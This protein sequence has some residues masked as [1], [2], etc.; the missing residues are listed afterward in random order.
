[1]LKDHL[2]LE[3]KKD[4]VYYIFVYL[5][6]QQSDL[7]PLKIKLEILFH[8]NRCVTWHCIVTCI[9]TCIPS[10]EGF[11]PTVTKL[12]SGQGNP[13]AATA[14]D[15]AEESNPYMSPFQKMTCIIFIIQSIHTSSFIKKF[16]IFFKKRQDQDIENIDI[17]ELGC[18]V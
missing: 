17:L 16:Q 4:Q 5:L 11:G 1:M 7:M 6:P 2:L 3:L 12:C 15:T 9:E 10:L 13:D 18:N 14:D 8:W